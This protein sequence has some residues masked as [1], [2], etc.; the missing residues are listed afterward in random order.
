LILASRPATQLIN[1]AGQVVLSTGIYSN[2]TTTPLPTL[3]GQTT[4]AT[5]INSSAEI[6]G[7]SVS[8]DIG[9]ADIVQ[10][11]DDI[12]FIYANGTLGS[13]PSSGLL[14][15][16]DMPQG[17]NDSG[18]IAGIRSVQDPNNPGINRLDAYIYDYGSGTTTDLG[19]GA[20]YAINASGAVTGEL[21]SSGFA[22]NSTGQ[23]VGYSTTA[24]NANSHA[25]FYNGAMNDLNTLVSATDPLKPYVTLT[26]AV[27]INDGLAV[28]GTS[29]LQ[30]VTVTN[31]GTAAIPIETASVNGDFS[32]RT[33]DCGTSLAPGGRDNP[34]R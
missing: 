14:P 32:L 34:R 24:V 11:Y 19:Q 8:P 7:Y 13:L 27:G 29:Q 25:F 2:G 1:N 28:G 15:I 22:I 18:L 4:P 20:G 26:G 23:V 6:V 5:V 12:G 3:P 9:P 21:D 33:D 10:G 17:I 30:S 16:T 31:A